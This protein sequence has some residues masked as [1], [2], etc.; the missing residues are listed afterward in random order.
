MLNGLDLPEPYELDGSEAQVNWAASIRDEYFG[1][2][3]Q[4]VRGTLSALALEAVEERKAAVELYTDCYRRAC[5]VTA[6][7]F[8]IDNRDRLKT[9]FVRHEGG[10]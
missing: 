6:A 8:W 5:E 10:I 3:Y 7:R 9:L 1:V 4:R 2:I